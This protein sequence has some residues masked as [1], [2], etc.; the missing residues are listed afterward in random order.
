MNSRSPLRSTVSEIPM[1]SRSP[2]A[3][4]CHENLFLISG[5]GTNTAARGTIRIDHLI[6]CEDLRSLHASRV[7]G[8][9]HTLRMHTPAGC[10][11]KPPSP[12]EQV[13]QP[14]Q[15]VVVFSCLYI[16]LPCY[17][18][19]TSYSSSVRIG[20]VALHSLLHIG[21]ETLKTLPPAKVTNSACNRGFTTD[22]ILIF[23]STLLLILHGFSVKFTSASSV[24]GL[25]T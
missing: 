18:F 8:G 15:A 25:E 1:N 4:S 13:P 16:K 19:F 23:T 9:W 12:H 24:P 3:P 7:L 6:H 14:A 21:L 22:F 17:W 2:H 5:N 10:T 11:R 20:V